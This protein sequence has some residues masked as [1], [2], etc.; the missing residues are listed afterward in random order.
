MLSIGLDMTFASSDLKK[1]A[2]LARLS[3]SE[4]ELGHLHEDMERIVELV[5]KLA[6]V[7]ISGIKPMS[8][9]GDRSLD[10]RPDHTHQVLG[11]LCIDSSRG[12]ED[13]LIRVPK[14]IE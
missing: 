10:L 14:I 2:R 13:G 11:R 5:E 8:H 9:A 7:D 4:E 1:I 6:E 3:W 12:Y